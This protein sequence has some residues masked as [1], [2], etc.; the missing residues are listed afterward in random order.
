MN[1]Q[2]WNTPEDGVVTASRLRAWWL[3]RFFGYRVV[4]QKL[5]PRV[6]FYGALQMTPRWI[7]SAPAT[8]PNRF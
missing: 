1:D 7:L 3:V 2:V 6:T 8:L 5:A 4:G